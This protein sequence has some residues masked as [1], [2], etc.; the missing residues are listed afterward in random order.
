[1]A[2]TKT[3][4]A[5][6]LVATTNKRQVGGEDIDDRLVGWGWRGQKRRQSGGGAGLAAATT[7]RKRAAGLVA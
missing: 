5:V 2:T 6:G 1:M 3:R 7:I 4:W